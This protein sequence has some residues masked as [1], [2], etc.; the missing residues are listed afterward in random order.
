MLLSA[1]IIK[2]TCIK[3]GEKLKINGTVSVSDKGFC[4]SGNFNTLENVY[5]G[6]FIYSQ[7]KDGTVSTSINN[8][9]QEYITD[10]Y[11]FLLDNIQE[12]TSVN[13]DN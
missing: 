13:F 5:C 7:R 1:D 2:Y 10:C 3:A 6:D 4:F 12:L 8:T 11:E 9:K